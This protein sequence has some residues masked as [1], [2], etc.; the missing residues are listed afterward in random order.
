MTLLG[1][2]SVQAEMNICYVHNDH[3]G[4]LKLMIDEN[5]TMVW[6]ADYDSFGK[7]IF[8]AMVEGGS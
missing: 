5:Q 2:L 8:K 6:T 4:T 1:S 7:A 3:L